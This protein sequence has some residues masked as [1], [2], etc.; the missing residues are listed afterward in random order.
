[1]IIGIYID[2]NFL[3]I[4]KKKVKV[5]KTTLLILKCTQNILRKVNFS[6]LITII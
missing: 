6:L 4:S 2:S 3:Y 1:M 5:P